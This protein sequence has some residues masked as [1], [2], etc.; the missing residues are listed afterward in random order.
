MKGSGEQG[1]WHNPSIAGEE[2]G[3]ER[4]RGEWWLLRLLSWVTLKYEEGDD[5]RTRMVFL[6][7][8][9]QMFF[10]CAVSYAAFLDIL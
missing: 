2:Q 4:G 9:P 5:R 7:F 6:V 10:S 3:D 8:S 1:M